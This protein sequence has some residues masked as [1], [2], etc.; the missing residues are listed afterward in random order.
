MPKPRTETVGLFLVL[1]Y[2]A[3]SFVAAVF[4]PN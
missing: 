1:L 2:A 3:V 4:R